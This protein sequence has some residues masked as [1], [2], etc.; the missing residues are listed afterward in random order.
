METDKIPC[1]SCGVLN[2]ETDSYCY[3]CGSSLNVSISSEIRKDIQ[4]NDYSSSSEFNGSERHFRFQ[5]II[6]LRTRHEKIDNTIAQI[7]SA[8]GNLF[9]IERSNTLFIVLFGYLFSILFFS[10]ILVPISPVLILLSPLIVLFIALVTMSRFIYFNVYDTR[11]QS[12]DSP[13]MKVTQMDHRRYKI[14]LKVK[15]FGIKNLAT[16][17]NW[18]LSDSKGKKLCSTNFTQDYGGFLETTNGNFIIS[19]V[20]SEKIGLYFK[21]VISFSVYNKSGSKLITINNPPFNQDEYPRI[22]QK[23]EILS[24]LEIDDHII[25]FFSFVILS[26]LIRLQ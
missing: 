11:S 2:D 4:N 19:C 23:F 24:S 21:D 12:T 13:R 16:R 8:T 17:K 20:P 22:P 3:D 14:G 18:V 5:K 6:H 26:K 9:T 10:I 1:P 15:Y 25:M 7:C